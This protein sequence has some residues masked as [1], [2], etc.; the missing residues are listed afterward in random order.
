MFLLDVLTVFLV[1]AETGVVSRPCALFVA[2]VW[3]NCCLAPGMV[4]TCPFPSLPWQSFLPSVMSIRF[5][6]GS[7][8]LV[9]VTQSL[10]EAQVQ[11]E[12]QLAHSKT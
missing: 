3:H 9:S 6:R 1:V 2:L 12:A 10:P 11:A 4:E 5:V 8:S 7:V